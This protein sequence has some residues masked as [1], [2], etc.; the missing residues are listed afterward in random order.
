[1]RK[2]DAKTQSADSTDYVC[3]HWLCTAV[4]D[5]TAQNSSDNKT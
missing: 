2:K 5:N 1:L 4:V 3:V